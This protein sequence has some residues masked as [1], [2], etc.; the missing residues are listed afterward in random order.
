MAD[1][2]T[3]YRG[4]SS[5]EEMISIGVRADQAIRYR[6]VSSDEEKISIGVRECQGGPGH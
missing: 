4:V 2:A 3:R 5:D 1:Q 6:G